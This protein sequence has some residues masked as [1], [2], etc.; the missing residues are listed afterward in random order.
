MIWSLLL[1]F[2][3]YGAW[4]LVSWMSETSKDL[5][6]KEDWIDRRKKALAAMTPT[7]LDVFL[8]EE[9]RQEDRGPDGHET[10]FSWPNM[11]ETERADY[12]AEQIRS[13]V[14]TEAELER[15]DQRTRWLD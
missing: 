5:S 2:G 13:R 8:K 11:T 10:P 7:E 6:A 12:R 4:K 9:R 1:L 15:D 14:D 3:G